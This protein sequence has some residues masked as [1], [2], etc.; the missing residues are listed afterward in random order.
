M[1]VSFALKTAIELAQNGN[2]SSFEFI[3]L[4]SF[5]FAWHRANLITKYNEDASSDIVQDAYV[6][7]YQ[8][9]HTLENIDSFL[10]EKNFK[11]IK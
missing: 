3:Y 5:S 9:I 2:K 4:E 10:K 11:G 6:I 8:K 7:C 1:E